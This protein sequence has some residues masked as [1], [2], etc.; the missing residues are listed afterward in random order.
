MIQEIIKE[1][2]KNPELQNTFNIDEIIEKLYSA[3]DE[4]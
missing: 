1:A 3:K 4:N 2:Q